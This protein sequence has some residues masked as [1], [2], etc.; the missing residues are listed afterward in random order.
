VVDRFWVNG[1]EVGETGINAAIA[2]YYGVPVVFVSGDL[3][4]TK[5]ALE[6]IPN[7]VSVAVKEAVTRVAAKCLNPKKAR[8]LI[9]KGAE[10]A[11][12]NRAS[13]PPF[14]V[15]SPVTIQ[16]KYVN[17]LMADIVEFLPFVERID[18]RTIRFVHDDYL[19]AFRAARATLYLASGTLRR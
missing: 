16:I 17:A 14:T 9:K 2:G 5:E 19:K 8:E 10:E 11:V 3:A 12:R 15:Q 4:V 7:I 6:I 1:L 13:I 18:G